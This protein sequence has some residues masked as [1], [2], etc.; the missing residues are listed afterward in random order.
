MCPFVEVALPDHHRHRRRRK[1]FSAPGAS[2]GRNAP[3]SMEKESIARGEV[4]RV[5]IED[6]AVSPVEPP[7]VPAECEALEHA[8]VQH[9][10][11]RYGNARR[12]GGLD[13][14]RVA[15]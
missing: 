9:L 14:N 8:G 5:P 15:V 6:L 13:E 11:A 2:Y 4:R 10:A 12:I 7:A 3:T 1:R